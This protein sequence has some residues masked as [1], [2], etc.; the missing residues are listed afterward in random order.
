MPLDSRLD[1]HHNYSQNCIVVMVARLL[2]VWKGYEP[3]CV[4]FF[5]DF[6]SST[7]MQN[8]PTQS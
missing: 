4:K 6:L 5:D 8:T 3:L 7:L 1:D 2:E